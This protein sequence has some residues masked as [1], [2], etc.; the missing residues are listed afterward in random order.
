MEA[1]RVMNGLAARLMMALILVSAV[2]AE[3]NDSYEVTGGKVVVG[4]PLTIGGRFDATSSAVSGQVTVVDTQREIGGTFAVDLRTLD[5]GIA[6]RSAHM[7]DTYLE[8]G[9]GPRFASAVLSH[10]VLDAPPAK[11]PNGPVGFQGQ[12]MLHGQTRPVT[13]N[14]DLSRKPGR[15]EVK[16]RFVVRIDEFQIAKPT[17]LGLGVSNEVEVTVRA[18]LQPVAGSSR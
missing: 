3:G 16:V 7:K 5:A 2:D 6:L 10:V 14:V 1:L 8:V 11:V 17:Y 4:C 12:L 18:T 13:G 9:R 15:L